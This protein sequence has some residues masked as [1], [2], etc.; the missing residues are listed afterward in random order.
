[1]TIRIFQGAILLFMSLLLNK[2]LA[3]GNVPPPFLEKIYALNCERSPHEVIYFTQ[4]PTFGIISLY[5]EQP[6][7]RTYPTTGSVWGSFYLKKGEIFQFEKN[8]YIEKRAVWIRGTQLALINSNGQFRENQLFYQLCGNNST[9]V[10]FVQS[11]NKLEVAYTQFEK[12]KNQMIRSQKSSKCLSF[13]IARQTC[14]SAGSYE[15]CMS[16]RYGEDWTTRESE[17][18]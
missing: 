9:A 11:G 10:R 18:K 1:M 16:I 4:H 2:A 15:R 13:N 14:A 6:S 7:N 3:Q 17:C 8:G 12:A 5:P